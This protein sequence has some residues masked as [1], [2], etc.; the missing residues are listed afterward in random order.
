VPWYHKVYIWR[1]NWG[2]IWRVGIFSMMMIYDFTSFQACVTQLLLT[3]LFIVLSPDGHETIM[4]CGYRL[5]VRPTN[6][7]TL[8]HVTSDFYSERIAKDKAYP[9]PLETA[10]N[11]T[12][13]SL[14]PRGTSQSFLEA[15]LKGSQMT[16]YCNLLE[17]CLNPLPSLY[18]ASTER[19]PH[20]V[21]VPRSVR[22]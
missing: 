6:D 1:Y 15:V 2:Y 18:Q 16:L 19:I 3:L 21:T 5:R 8:D 17:T 10:V 22:H 11:C 14:Y 4:S 13:S 9:V 20:W 12:H 7:I